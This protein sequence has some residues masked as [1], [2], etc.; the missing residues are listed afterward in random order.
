M[1]GSFINC[2]LYRLE[3][4]QSF[5]KGRSYCPHCKH[6]LGFWDLIPIFSFIFLKA[7][8]RYCQK[9]ISWQYPLIE[10]ITGI[11]FIFV[12]LETKVSIPFIG[13][14][15]ISKGIEALA[16]FNYLI[17][18]RN[19][20]FSA[21]L[22]IIFVY[23]LKHQLVSEKIVIPAIIIA[24]TFN[25]FMKISP[26]GIPAGSYGVNWLDLLLGVIIGSS[27]FLSQYLISKGRWIGFGDVY[28]G[29]M[30]GAMLGWQKVILAIILAYFIGAMIAVILIILKKESWKS[31][32]ALGPFLMIGTFIA[33]LYG[34][35]ILEWY[36]G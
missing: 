1:A 30:M 35:K 34:N 27:F 31:K 7:K 26:I 6:Q 18:F 20:F 3:Q 33:L 24:L 21:V 36:L 15:I 2:I 5:I 11:I 22:I 14:M 23:D 8:C 13:E 17:L 29:F 9:K 16:S 10:I 4:N 19:L 12:Y 25:F 28:L 32:I